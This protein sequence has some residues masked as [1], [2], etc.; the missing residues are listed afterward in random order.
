MLAAGLSPWIEVP[1]WFPRSSPAFHLLDISVDRAFAHGFETRPVEDTLRQILDWD[2]GRRGTP[3]KAGFAREKE[4]AL[5][6]AEAQ[7]A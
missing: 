7:T 2:R 5:L 3:L 1:L 4:A 6:A